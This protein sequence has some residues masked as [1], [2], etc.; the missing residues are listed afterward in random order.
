MW[1]KARENIAGLG[2]VSGTLYSIDRALQRL[3]GRCRIYRYI[4]V[5]QPVPQ[6]PVLNARRGRSIAVRQVGANDPA[7]AAMPLSGEVIRYRFAQNA[8]C[9][10]A[11]QDGDMIG[12]LWLRLGSYLEDEV[13]CRFAPPEGA[14]WDF[15]V[16]IAPERRS[17]FAFTRLWDEAN[18]YLREHGIGW[19]FSRI[20]AFNPHSMTS[21]ERMGARPTGTATYLRLGS[22]Q[23]ML[24]SLAPYVHLSTGRRSV[25]SLVLRLPARVSQPSGDRA[26]A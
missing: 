16:Y 9:F 23:L 15:D 6:R 19:S 12:C 20:S 18:A 4:L 24:S 22:W 7:L 17:S 5:A 2:I 14:A 8:L 3:T 25:P 10:G 11:F 13:R 21:H 1:R 26:A